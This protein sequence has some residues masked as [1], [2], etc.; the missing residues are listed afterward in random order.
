MRIASPKTLLLAAGC[1]TGLFG[2][3]TPRRLDAG[4]FHGIVRLDGVQRPGEL[5]ERGLTVLQ[6]TPDAAVVSGPIEAAG[7]AELLEAPVK[8]S[9]ELQDSDV[10]SP[11]KFLA[12]FYADVSEGDMR[13]I[14]DREGLAILE[15]PDLLSNH[16]MLEGPIGRIERLALWDEVA[17]VWPASKEL[18]RGEPVRGCAGALTEYGS[19]GQYVATIGNGWD[20]A[21]LGAAT[22]SYS[23]Q[24]G[25]SGVSAARLAEEIERALSEWARVVRIEFRYGGSPQLARHLNFLF[26]RGAHG[27]PYP[28]D[29][30]GRVLAHTF[31]PAP[32]NPEPLAGDLHFDDDENWQL[33]PDTDVYSVVLHELGHALGL[34][35][36]DKPSAVMY[37]VSVS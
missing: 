12:E 1:L 10:A 24:Q 5:A 16:L 17:Y 25:A 26:T 23:I 21:G 4:R 11:V 6:A 7:A 2:Q 34:G 13:T 27:D 9:R 18:S 22:L 15:H 30:R 19:I 33:G 35:H 36:S 31:Y 28:F 32:P 37:T 8:I 20:G 29:G 14:A 3:A